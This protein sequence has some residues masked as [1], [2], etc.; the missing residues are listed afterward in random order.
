MTGRRARIVS[1]AWAVLS[2]LA[3]GIL[4]VRSPAVKSLYALPIERWG[5]SAAKARFG[6][7]V[8][9]RAF[10]RSFAD[11][12][13]R[14]RN[15]DTPPRSGACWPRPGAARACQRGQIWALLP[16]S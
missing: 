12:A 10:A 13:S 6:G 9:R 8:N 11:L 14:R 16:K 1:G 15:V 4:A 5:D 2:W 7:W 3:G